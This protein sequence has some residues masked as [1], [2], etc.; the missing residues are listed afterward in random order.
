M[1]NRYKAEKLQ[2]KK[3]KELAA[4][5]HKLFMQQKVKALPK[6]TPMV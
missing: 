2:A 6:K 4:E 5:K 3:E 1:Y